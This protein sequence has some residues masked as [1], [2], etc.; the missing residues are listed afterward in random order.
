MAKQKRVQRP[1]EDLENE[2][3]EQIR[4]LKSACATYDAGLESMAKHIALVLRVL[5]HHHGQSRSLLEQLGLLGGMR[6]YDTAR[7]L[8]PENMMTES[9]L[10]IMEL[11]DKGGRFVPRFIQEQ[12]QPA[13]IPR[14][15]IAEWWN[16][17]VIKDEKGSLFNRRLLVLNVA[18]TDG[19]AHVDPELEEAYM[20]LSRKNSLGWTFTDGNITK[21]LK[22]PEL[23]CIR[24]IAEEVLMSMKD[25]KAFMDEGS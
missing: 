22:G 6:F 1:R 19:G 2:L 17:F 16:K 23:A 21:A 11:S 13:D 4:L 25:L 5:I 14:I 12:R 18:D 15:P 7:S 20:E 8:K 10:T 24:Q 9:T 3:R